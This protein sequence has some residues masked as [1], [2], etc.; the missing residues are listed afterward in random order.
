MVS[1]QNSV[2]PNGLTR[3]QIASAQVAAS[4]DEV[5]R[6]KDGTAVPYEIPIYSEP[7]SVTQTPLI[8]DYIESDWCQSWK[9][10]SARI[11]EEPSSDESTCDPKPSLKRRDKDRSVYS[12]YLKCAGWVLALLYVVLVLTFAFCQNF[13]SERFSPYIEHMDTDCYNPKLSG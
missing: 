8:E 1:S 10:L 7:D 6:L 13:S 12:F 3:D 2:V 11:D 5:Y 9:Q 4:A